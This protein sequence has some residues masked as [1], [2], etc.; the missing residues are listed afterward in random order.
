MEA[1]RFDRSL[2]NATV[3]YRLTVRNLGAEALAEVSL[4][5][6]LVTAS[7]DRPAEQQLALPD[8]AL[9]PRHRAE[10][11]AAGESLSFEGQAR[12]PLAQATAIR[13]GSVGVLVPL[14]RVRATAANA[15]PVAATLVVGQGASPAA[16]PQPFPLDDP[17]RSY[18]P[19]AQRLLDAVPAAA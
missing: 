7:S 1:T 13:Q 11:L 16:R 19:L 9:E 2:F 8:R 10:R 5:A 4:E 14:L 12:L 18:A 6:D 15:A 17:P 3:A